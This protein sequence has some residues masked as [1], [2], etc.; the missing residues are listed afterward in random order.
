MHPRYNGHALTVQVSPLQIQYRTTVATAMITHP[1]SK[2][3]KDRNNGY[4]NK[5]AGTQLSPTHETQRAADANEHG[6][7]D[8]PAG[9]T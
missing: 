1:A 8:D 6:V 9:T 7:R 3:T 5:F 4:R 2:A